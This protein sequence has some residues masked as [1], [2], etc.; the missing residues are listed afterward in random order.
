MKDK[1]ENQDALLAETVRH[2]I[3]H[4]KAVMAIALHDIPLT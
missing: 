1:T 4:D 2:Y 3:G